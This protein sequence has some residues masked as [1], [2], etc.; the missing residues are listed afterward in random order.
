MARHL[1][2]SDWVRR[3][4]AGEPPEGAWF[5]CGP[6]SLLRDRILAQIRESVFGGEELARHGQDRFYGGEG[7]VA[8]ITSALVSVG[9]FSGTRLVTLSDTER[10]GRTGA[11]EREELLRVLESG[12]PGSVFVASSDLTPWELERKNEFT[13][14]LMAAC[15]VVELAHPTP[16]E[17]MRWLLG[18]SRRRGI[19]LDA[20]AGEYLVTRTGPY[21][22]ELS[23]ELEKLET[24]TKPGEPI[25]RELLQDLAGKGRIGTGVE[26][27]NAV[28]ASRTFDAL[29]LLGN[30]GRTEPVLRLQWLIQRRCR[31]CLSTRTHKSDDI[32]LGQLLQL[33]HELERSIKQGRVPSGRDGTALEIAVASAATGLSGSQSGSR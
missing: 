28:L 12:M 6:E 18:E 23:R 15:K 13:R 7:S 11:A 10:F 5:L 14:R 30:L 29:R 21:L 32:R 2:Y 20:D 4:E 16:A 25:G 26:F 31:D 9:L 19:L 8:A 22:Q 3:C 33:M 27:V 24:C 1:R 17:S